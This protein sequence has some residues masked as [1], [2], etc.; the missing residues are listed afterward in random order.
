MYF[1]IV[2]NLKRLYNC[3]RLLFKDKKTMTSNETTSK[4]FS[5][6]NAVVEL[7]VCIWEK[8]GRERFA[9]SMLGSEYDIRGK[10]DITEV[11]ETLDY[12]IESEG[13]VELRG[14]STAQAQAVC[15]EIN[16]IAAK[17][18]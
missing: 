4:T 18:W 10:T 8:H 14:Y 5:L 13:H 1:L 15:D 12:M 16:R 3:F 17:F 9:A 7:D 6:G 11:K 2:S